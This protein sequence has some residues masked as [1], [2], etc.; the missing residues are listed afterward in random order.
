MTESVQSPCISVCLLN[1]DDVCTGCYRTSDE[2]VDW[3][4]ADD[5]RKHEIIKAC[6]E[7]RDLANPIKLL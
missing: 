2:I 1:E 7:R 6:A 4:M 3:F 5:T